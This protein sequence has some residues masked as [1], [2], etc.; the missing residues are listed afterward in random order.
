MNFKKFKNNRFVNLAALSALAASAVAAT[1]SA[2]QA[3]STSSA[4]LANRL[5]SGWPAILLGVL[6]LNICFRLGLV[7]KI[8]NLDKRSRRLLIYAPVSLFV[9][10]II[11]S[12]LIYFLQGNLLLA[13]VIA[14]GAL[15]VVPFVSFARELMVAENN[16]D[17][18][19]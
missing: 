9:A 16:R 15:F 4:S 17:N 1:A 3:A 19:P 14:N 2:A 12:G 7:G 10:L 18:E 13:R 8:R 6:V 11:I 5:L